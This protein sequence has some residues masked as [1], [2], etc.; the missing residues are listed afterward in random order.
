MKT[1]TFLLFLAPFSYSQVSHNGEWW[2]GL[3]RMS[4]QEVVTGFLDGM[5][6]GAN[7]TQMGAGTST[8][9]DCRSKIS[10]SYSYVQTRYFARVAPEEIVACLDRLYADA[11]NASIILGRA[12][13]IAVNQLAGTPEEDIDKLIQQSRGMGY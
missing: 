2:T 12:V 4:K 7:L 3:S 1:L 6:L 13:W 9:S 5:A 11:D 10:A 8:D